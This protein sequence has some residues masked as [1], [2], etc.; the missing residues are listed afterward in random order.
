MNKNLLKDSRSYLSGP[1][2]F[3]GSRIIEKYYGWRAIITPI[4][5]TLGIS[6]L[7]PWNKPHVKGLDGLNG[8]E[9]ILYS[10]SHYEKDFWENDK[11]RARFEK[12]FWDT[13]HIDLRMVDVADFLISFVPTNIY[14]V[15][16]AHEIVVARRQHKPVLLISPPVKY[17]FFPELATLSE[18]Q[19][20]AL[21]NY[22]LKENPR[23]IP[24][25]WY[26]NIVG[27]YNFFDGFGWE[28]LDFK[29]KD[30]Y[31]I[32]FENIL[33]LSKPDEEALMREEGDKKMKKKI[34]DE[35]WNHWHQVKKWISGYKP[36]KLL[37]GNV[38]KHQK[39]PSEE[40][41][42]LFY[43]TAET[44]EETARRYFWYNRPYKPK[45]PVL[46]TLLSITCG[47][48]AP[49]FQVIHELTAP[50]KTEPSIHKVRND[51]WMLITG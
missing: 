1:M 8:E 38:E 16:T 32:L 17:D 44:P 36:L 25:Q 34:L 5:K 28:N 33:E 49:K 43:K 30:F 7:D 21:K 12:D 51:D 3:V 47:I 39:F 15:G 22:G 37:T 26:G 42:A 29:S 9:S 13:V 24:S 35:K 19:K 4:L 41:Q 2:D 11:T 18:K 48:I 10:K 40:E 31:N 14:S 20:K 50:G 27:G 6:P 46:Y 45:R 23:G